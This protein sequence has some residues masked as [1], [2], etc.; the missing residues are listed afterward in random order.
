[1]RDHLREH[2]VSDIQ[3]VKGKRN[4]DLL[5][6]DTYILTFEKYE[7]LRVIK[8]SDWHSELVDEYKPRP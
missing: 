1:M 7:R 2:K 3:R 5:T 4:R 6:T 8:L